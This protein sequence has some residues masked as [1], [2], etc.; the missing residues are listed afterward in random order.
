MALPSL[1]K[2][3]HRDRKN[4]GSREFFQKLRKEQNAKRPKQVTI[5]DEFI[6]GEIKITGPIRGN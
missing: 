3:S 5:T 6:N 1:S 2:K 4:P